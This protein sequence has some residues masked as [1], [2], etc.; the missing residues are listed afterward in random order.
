[1]QKL[2]SR[3]T[4]IAIAS[5]GLPYGTAQRFLQKSARLIITERIENSINQ[6]LLFL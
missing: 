6:T 5:I 1:M 2:N 3:A 4:F